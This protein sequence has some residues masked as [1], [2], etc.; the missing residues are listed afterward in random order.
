MIRIRANLNGGVEYYKYRALLFREI[1]SIII[2]QLFHFVCV[3]YCLLKMHS[4][5]TILLFYFGVII[6]VQKFQ[7]AAMPVQQAMNLSNATFVDKSDGEDQYMPHDD[8]ETGSF[9]GTEMVLVEEENTTQSRNPSRPSKKSQ[10]SDSVL[11]IMLFIAI[12]LATYTT[13]QIGCFLKNVLHKIFCS[14]SVARVRRRAEAEGSVN[15][16]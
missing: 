15:R 13:V 10:Y 5:A 12:C 9:N 14:R 8:Y 16:V 4:F 6:I 11:V 1:H 2:R 7:I 3:T